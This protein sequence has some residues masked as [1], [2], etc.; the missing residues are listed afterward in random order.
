[1]LERKASSRHV[2]VQGVGV[3]GDA[4]GGLTAA[5]HNA[6]D[7][8][9]TTQAAARTFPCIAPGFRGETELMCH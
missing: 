9:F 5:V 4:G 3:E 7:L 8:A 2:P 1:M 6:G